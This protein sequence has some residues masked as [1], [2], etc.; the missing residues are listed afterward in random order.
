MELA[1]A[2]RGGRD[3]TAPHGLVLMDSL[4]P[5]AHQ[6]A[7]VLLIIQICVIPGQ[8]S[9]SASLA[10]MG[11][12]A[13]VPAHSTHMERVAV[14]TAVVRMMP[15]VHQSM[16]HA[17]VQQVT[18]AQTAVSCVRVAHL[19]K[20]VL[21][22]VTVRMVPS[23]PVRMGV[24]IAHQVG[25]VSSATDLAMR[26]STAGIATHHAGVSTTQRATPR[27]GHAH[28]HQATWVSCVSGSVSLDGLDW[29]AASCATVMMTTALA[30]TL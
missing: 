15:N 18:G 14:T 5:H 1:L 23:A 10:G 13:H 17:S 27:M 21:K 3:V 9:V 25:K 26:N 19:V 22:G 29:S 4:G 20:T 30:V 12:Y 11:R 8:E 24:V 7:S 16:E 6:C 2:H 28:V